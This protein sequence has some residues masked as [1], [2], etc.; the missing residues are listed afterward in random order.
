MEEI[1]KNGK[2]NSQIKI[3][4]EFHK[5][6]S[7]QYIN[8]ENVY[9]YSIWKNKFSQITLREST[10]CMIKNLC[11]FILGNLFCLFFYIKPKKFIEIVSAIN[12]I[13][14]NIFNTFISMTPFS[15]KVFQNNNRFHYL[16]IVSCI[17]CALSTI[18]LT[19]I[20]IEGII[21]IKHKRSFFIIFS[22]VFFLLGV[23]I[24]YKT[25]SFLNKIT[26]MFKFFSFISIIVITIFF[27]SIV[28]FIISFVWAY[29]FD[30]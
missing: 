15:Y 10:I 30:K 2:V 23:N 9:V 20:L 13:L 16:I 22:I 24:E 7:K 14:K 6:K 17:I 5:E 11:C 18:I 21:S 3:K 26:I 4:K 19:W 12:I 28:F 29:F 27:Y 8:G 25:F 1:N